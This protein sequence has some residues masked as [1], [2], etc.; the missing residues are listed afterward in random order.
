MGLFFSP[1]NSI[2]PFFPQERRPALAIPRKHFSPPYK[3]SN[4]VEISDCILYI[5]VDVEHY[6]N[7]RHSYTIE[8]RQ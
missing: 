7:V 2:I 3:L 8:I 6:L 5:Y 4:Y 1:N